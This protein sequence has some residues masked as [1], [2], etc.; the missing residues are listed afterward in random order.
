MPDENQTSGVKDLERVPGFAPDD[1]T[2]GRPPLD[3]QSK[4]PS[5][6]QSEILKEAIYLA[7]LLALIPVAMLLF[8]MG[9]PNRWL[10]LSDA[11][12]ASV[13]KYALAWLGGTLGGTLYD[14]KWLYHVVARRVW[15]LDRRL[16]RLFT[17]HLSGGLAFAMIAII[18]S[19]ILRIFDT[20]ASE[21]RSLVIAVAFL[22]GY[23]SDTAVAKLSEIA[24]TIFGA[25]R[26]T[27]KHK[28][29]PNQSKAQQVQLPPAF[30]EQPPNDSSELSAISENPADQDS[31]S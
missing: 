1:P 22:V 25:S 29:S 4:Y 7:V 24:E 16:W 20:Q 28:E 30:G 23:F 9:Y 21:S 6:A 2:D 11:T 15:H 3:W 18:S 17:P 5:A 14:I 13:V 26:A 8:W 31:S 10:K 12:Y 19:G 27:E